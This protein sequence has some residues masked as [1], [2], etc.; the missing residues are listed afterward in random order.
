LVLAGRSFRSG[1]SRSNRV[2]K[3]YLKKIANI[4]LSLLG[5]GI[6][7]Q[8]GWILCAALFALSMISCDDEKKKHGK[9]GGGDSGSET[10][11]GTV[12]AECGTKV[13]V[14]LG[15]NGKYI[16]AVSVEP[17]S[18]PL[19]VTPDDAGGTVD[20]G[21]TRTRV[22]DGPR[23]ISFECNPDGE[24]KC[25]ATYVTAAAGSSAMDLTTQNVSGKC[26]ETK[27]TLDLGAGRYDLVV[28]VDK[29]SNCSVDV[30][31]LEASS[32]TIDIKDKKEWKTFEGGKTVTITCGS[33]TGTKCIYSFTLGRAGK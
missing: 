16:V 12:P 27:S 5:G 31:G 21:T 23:D 32:V 3:P 13:P 20:P 18:C 2:R 25:K 24:K 7:K 19:T 17:D 22:V 26:S 14:S 6:V 28:T 11:P 9:G 29:D 10:T 30:S 15:G 4:E 33:G 1:L 8:V